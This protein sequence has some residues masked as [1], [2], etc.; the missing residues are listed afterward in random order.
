MRPSWLILGS[1]VA[2][3]LSVLALLTQPVATAQPP[4]P[5]PTP[6]LRGTPI[7][8]TP[9]FTSEP[10][11][12]LPPTS[13][14]F[15]PTRPPAPAG[16][17]APAATDAPPAATDGSPAATPTGSPVPP[18]ATPVTNLSPDQAQ[19]LA[20][21]VPITAT[22]TCPVA[23]GCGVGG[24]HAYF[25]ADVKHT[26]PLIALTY[27]LAPGTDTF[28]ALYRPAP[29]VRDTDTGIS[30]WQV[31]TTNDDAVVGRTLRSQLQIS[32]DWAGPALLLVR[33]GGSPPRHASADGR[34]TLL[35]GPPD[36][37][38]VRTVLERLAV[39]EGVAPTPDRAASAPP[40]AAPPAAAPPPAA[41][42]AALPAA[43][44]GAAGTP[45]P[46]PAA[47]GD[48]EQIINEQD[49]TIGFATVVRD[50]AN[51]YGAAPPD[52]R[53][54]LATYP[55]DSRIILLG[56]CY[57]GWVKVQPS[58]SVTPGWMF[59]P[60][61]RLIEAMAPTA[62][63]QATAKALLV[64]GGVPVAPL[65]PP[66]GTDG[67]TAASTAST[68]RPVRVVVQPAAAASP[69]PAAQPQALTVVVRV[70]DS[71]GQP[72]PGVRVRLTSAFGDALLDTTTPASGQVTLPVR[73][74]AGARVFVQLPA[75]GVTLPVDPQ[76]P[77][78]TITLPSPTATG[79][80]Q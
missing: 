78:L 31:V 63:A 52:E 39:A 13:T 7:V 77:D 32:P 50:A 72:R 19:P 45:A 44:A 40:V 12:A 22:L 21:G 55:K 27:D 17:A 67:T 15:V 14:I 66:G 43:T 18:G 41:P 29:G 35:V 33:P 71:V 69:T 58:D 8:V 10:T 51:F 16:E 46:A 64:G 76:Q 80:P 53:R 54:L 60:D 74:A 20:W 34:Y 24:F 68:T 75:Q 38:A 49:C 57:L 59:G 79:G 26:V 9:V 73:V 1:T 56:T 65:P 42:P 25:L 37:P 47:G 5:D 4:E 2:T 62:G 6:L 11:V 61:L 70:V 3:V 30:D 23:W 36:L 28:L 48:A